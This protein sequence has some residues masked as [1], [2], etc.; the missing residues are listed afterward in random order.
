MELLEDSFSTPISWSP[1]GAGTCACTHRPD[2]M[3]FLDASART[4]MKI[5]IKTLSLG[6][7]DVPDITFELKRNSEDMYLFSPYGVERVYGMPFADINVTKYAR[8][9]TTGASKRRRS[10]PAPSSRPSEDPVQVRLPYVMFET[11]SADP[12]HQ[13][14]G[15]GHVQ[16]VF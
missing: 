13:G 15:H 5:R 3:R 9:W 7:V 6:V 11:R 14:Q 12:T 1:P 8:W 10:T 16:P 4:P 2:I